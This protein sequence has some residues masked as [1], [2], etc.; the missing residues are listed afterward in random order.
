MKINVQSLGILASF[1]FAS[2]TNAAIS[3]YSADFSVDGQG[4]THD[5][6]G[7]DPID[8]SPISG[9]NWT[10]SF[11]VPSSDGSTNEFITT[12]GVMRV[13][14]W[15]GDGTVTSLGITIADTGLVQ[16]IGGALSIG[17][18]SFNSSTEGIT[19][20]YSINSA[21]PVEVVV[22]EAS[23]ANGNVNAGTDVGHTFVD[24]AV[25]AGDTLEVGFTVNVNGLGDGVEVSSLSVTAVPEPSTALLGSL[26][27]LGLLRRKR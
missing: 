18:D 22:N 6:S 16:I 5:T 8:A 4:S 23:L 15:G 14:D 17:D 3:I 10:L 12:G 26:A 2:F 13:Q 1:S 19:W 20:F 7:S 11:P 24:V 25:T 21:A 27:L 9:A